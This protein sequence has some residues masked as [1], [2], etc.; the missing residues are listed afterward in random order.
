MNT[1]IRAIILV[2]I[3]A[4]VVAGLYYVYTPIPEKAATPA[5][6]ATTAP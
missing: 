6:A 5:P 4:A 2:L 1:V 3:V